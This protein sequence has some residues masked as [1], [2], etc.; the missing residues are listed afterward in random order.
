MRARSTLLAL[1]ALSTVPLVGAAEI[2]E[3]EVGPGTTGLLIE[4]H[5]VP[6]VSV[7][8]E[9]PVGSWSP[10]AI[11]NDAETA[12]TIQNRDPDGALR[13][14]ADRLAV[15]LQLDVGE[16]S[17]SVRI[18]CGK[19]DLPEALRL[20]RD[21]L[22]NRSFDRSELKRRRQTD[23]LTWKASLKEPR[24][25]LWQAAARML[26][27]ADD[28][29]RRPFEKP[30]P[31][32]TDPGRLAAARDTLVRIPGRVVGF[33]GDLTEE[34]A[35]SLAV[36]LLPPPLEAPPDGLAP[37]VSPLTPRSSRPASRT[38][39]LPR[40]TQVYFAYGRDSLGY[41]DPDYPASMIV[42]HAL[43]GHFNSRLMVALRQDEGDTY[44]AS[45]FHEGGLEP[46]AYGLTTFT[47]T[48]NAAQVASK[49][50]A[51]LARLHEQGITEE[52]RA[53]AAGNVVGRR[54][55]LRQSPAQILSTAME[56]RRLALPYG[57]FDRL[58]ER[59]ATLPLDEINAFARRFHDPEAFTML[60]VRAKE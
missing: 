1:L 47:R 5:R 33:A 19:A 36:D 41:R 52:E 17:S 3:W 42:D 57:F 4:D 20:A 15:S 9:F 49:L 11:R 53:L 26:F 32:E 2:R 37:A 18:S 16:R 8:V 44:G 38:V 30:E 50:E 23:K 12:F 39:E 22:A 31:S 55:F 14:R 6:L 60:T 56:E 10:W 48:D 29:R 7:I 24:F 58:A 43:G 59:A 25:V 40:L 28:P 45:V 46:G 34:A 21:V 51:V 35:R 13:R 27:V 54:A